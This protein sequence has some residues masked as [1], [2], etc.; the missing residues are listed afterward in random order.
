MDL[1]ADQNHHQEATCGRN[2]EHNSDDAHLQ[3]DS[4]DQHDYTPIIDSGVV[5]GRSWEEG[6]EYMYIHVP[7]RPSS[8]MESSND[9][10]EDEQ[11]CD[12]IASHSPE[13]ATGGAAKMAVPPQQ[14]RQPLQLTSP[15][16]KPSN[17]PRCVLIHPDGAQADVGASESIKQCDDQYIN[18]TDN[19]VHER[20]ANM[21]D[22]YVYMTGSSKTIVKNID[23]NS[24]VED[25]Y[26][27]MACCSSETATDAIATN[28]MATKLPQVWQQGQPRQ[29]LQNTSLPSAE[30]SNTPGEASYLPN[31]S[32]NWVGEGR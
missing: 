24:E 13:L 10:S 30:P 20:S 2:V 28:T 26:I 14:Y 3:D 4:D 11:T 9:S 8:E 25:I 29:P 1:P 18:F 15:P 17:P 32:F 12:E 31:L 23:E 27:E 6:D 7:R 19:Q 5:Y 21:G 16:V 22:E